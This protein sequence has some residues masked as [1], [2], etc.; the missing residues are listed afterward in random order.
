MKARSLIVIVVLAVLAL[1]SST[2]ATAQGPQA[3][4]PP[5]PTREP[6]LPPGARPWEPEFGKPFGPYRTPDGYWAVPEGARPAIEAAGVSPQG[7]GGPDDFGYTWD[8]SVPF[9]W[10]DATGGTDTGL[11]GE[12]WGKA[13]GPIS[14]PFSF[15]Y[16]ENTYTS[17]YIAA[18]G[19]LGFTDEETWL[20]QSQIPLPSTPNN[21]IAPYWTPVYIGTGSWIRYLSGGTAPNR[22]F[23]VEWHNVRGG[24]PSDSI[25]GDDT[26][27]FEVILYEN[28]DIVF[29]YQTMA[30]SA[31]YWCGAAGIEDSTG[32]DGLAYV[33]FCEQAPSNRAVRFYRPAPSA[34]VDI[35]P[36]FQGRF[37]RA[38]ATETFQVPIRNTGELGS[39]T[40]DLYV[41]SLWPVSLYAADGA[42]PLT[43]TDGD[44]TVDTGSV[45]QGST[46]TVTVKVQTP[47]LATVGDD[48][49]AAVTVR[50][51]RNTSTSKTVTLQTAVPAPFA[52]VYQETADGAMSLYLVQP[53]A[54]AVKK[55][56]S[57]W[58]GGYDVAVAETPGGNFV[59]AWSKGRCLDS[60][61]NVYGSEIEYALLE[62]YGNV[63]RPVSRLTDHTG[64][65]VYTYDEAP[66]VAVAPNGRIGVLWYR[67]LWD[68]STARF[69]YNIYFAILDASGNRVYGPLNLT[70]NNAWGTWSDLGVPRF[71]SPR[72]AATGDNRFVLAWQ[73]AHQESG[74]WVNDIYYT[75][76]DNTGGEIKAITR[77]TRDTPGDA[78]YYAPSLA[79]LSSN[80]AFVSWASR[81]SGNDDIYYAI[82]GSNGNLVKTATD[83]SVDEN[84]IDWSNYDA[85]QLSDGRILAV[86]QAWGCF[87]GEWVPRIRFALLD[88]SYNR[89]GMPACLGKAEAAITGDTSVSLAADATGHAIL[90]WTDWAWSVRRNLYYALV[91][92]N[93]NVLTPPMIFRTAGMS[94]WGSQYIETSYEGCGNTSYSWTPPSGVDGVAAF[95]ASLF[96]GPPGGNAAVALHYANQGATVATNV[97]VTA[98]LGGGLTYVSDSSGVVPSISGDDVVWGLPDLGFLD[99]R[100]FTLYAGV[101]SGADYGT[102]YPITLTLTSSGLEA[103]PSDNTASAEVMAARQVLLPVIMRK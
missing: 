10:I 89:I 48:N 82:V 90:T 47:A 74:G 53:G 40:Y 28:S 16:Y 19:Y 88:T 38:G 62:R 27:R 102:R 70:N 1:L 58:Y 13:V 14:L 33:R 44:G 71:Y 49:A 87:P 20:A 65:T 32:W 54:Q 83:L 30:Y 67:Y 9:H 60:N 37:T 43:D 79:S 101:P 31:S 57:D 51:S 75:V 81:Q 61:C 86:W 91:D 63:V 4:A 80:R 24:S 11:S 66:A 85:V 3:P 69:N 7:S 99:S 22:Y 50:S 94:P 76:R 68:D 93:G 35:R 17:L 64:A 77:L 55:A 95:S 103:N 23:V 100:G 41:S 5:Y 78:G 56:T 73:R 36:A 21:V 15:K 12:S 25:G 96:G 46:V 39:D 45:A 42:T 52:Q 2:G 34:R 26:Y 18:S 59:Y 29:Q 84:V 92:G 8:D 6:G 98:T 72:I 97:V